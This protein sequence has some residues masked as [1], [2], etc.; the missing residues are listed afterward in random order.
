[1][2]T[3]HIKVS[4]AFSL[5]FSFSFFPPLS[6]FLSVAPL[7]QPLQ[8]RFTSF[9]Q[10]FE[11]SWHRCCFWHTSNEMIVFPCVRHS[12]LK[13]CAN[14]QQ[15]LQFLLTK[16]EFFSACCYYFF[17]IGC[18]LRMMHLNSQ[19]FFSLP[20][21]ACTADFFWSFYAR[22][23]RKLRFFYSISPPSFTFRQVAISKRIF[24]QLGYAR[25]KLTSLTKHSRV[26]RKKGACKTLAG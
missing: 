20:C 10:L 6:F 21:L 15:K 18:I 19:I 3:W 17:L 7:L 9:H 12:I 13:T 2:F 24:T 23:H 14:R 1:M 16:Y 25:K 8:K 11:R 5:I 22:V 26:A 4:F